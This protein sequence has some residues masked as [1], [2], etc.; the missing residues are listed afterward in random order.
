MPN[1]NS[2]HWLQ[3]SKSV[4][5]AVTMINICLLY[6]METLTLS[7]PVIVFLLVRICSVG[8]DRCGQCR[9]LR[10]WVINAEGA[11]VNFG[12]VKSFEKKELCLVDHLKLIKLISTHRAIWYVLLIITKMCPISDCGIKYSSVM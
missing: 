12:I 11:K 5:N 2:S 1:Q 8:V 4:Y 10:K 7:G 9:H 6:V 3:S